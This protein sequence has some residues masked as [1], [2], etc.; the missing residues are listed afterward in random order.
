SR[1]HAGPVT[2]SAYDEDHHTIA[3]HYLPAQKARILLML[4]LA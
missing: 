1:I 3:S 4:C 2:D